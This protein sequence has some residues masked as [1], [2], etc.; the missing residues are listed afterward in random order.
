MRRKDREVTDKSKIRTII[1]HC[2]CCRIG[3]HDDG[4]V[5]IVPMNFGYTY[6]NDKYTFYF[7]GAQVGRKVELMKKSPYVG[8]E[9]DTNYQLTEGDAACEY[10]ARFQSVIGNGN[11]SIVTDMEEK[12]EGLQIVMEHNTGKRDWEFPENMLKKVGVFKLEVTDLA[13]KEYL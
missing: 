8:F 10:S 13:C 4:E 9:M 12:R 7:H 3:F 6:E 5:Y 1:D 11:I 2:H